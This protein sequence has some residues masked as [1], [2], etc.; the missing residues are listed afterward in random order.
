MAVEF[1]GN[2]KTTGIGSLP[3]A[4]CEEAVSF[5]LDAGLSIPFW[6]QLP[7]RAFIERMVPQFSEFMPC[8]RIDA[9][10]GRIGF[11]AAEKYHHL[12]GFY[13]AFLSEDL[14][15]FALSE[16][17]AAGLYAFQRRAAGRSWPIVKGHITG[18]LTFCMGICDAD[19][20]PLY[21]DADLRDAAVKLLT[22]KA[23]WQ[24]ERLRPLAAES[25]LIFVDEPILAAYGSSAYLGI[26]EE[27][28]WQLTGEV[29]RAIREA[30]AVAGMHVCGNSDWGV[31]IRTG[32]DVLNFDAWQYGPTIALY[33]EQ[34][35]ALLDRGGCIAWGVVPTVTVADADLEA[36][37]RRLD[38]CL[39]ALTAKGFD[40]EE[41]RAASLLTPACGTGSIPFENARKTFSL[42][43]QLGEMVIG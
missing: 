36:V 7:K 42:L 27:D 14:A 24:I 18:P 12:E 3:I 13:E 30:G 25:V 29:I 43:R 32:V 6:P 15:P 10:Q 9:A 33:V 39:D 2:L 16:E 38:E 41:L 26:C 17:A 1:R 22:R 23:Q 4:E 40:R 19:K 34:V 21:A 5:V 8:V 37:V 31:M 35:R 28:V 11:D 20:R